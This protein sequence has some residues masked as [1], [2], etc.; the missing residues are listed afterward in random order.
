M[1]TAVG[2][3]N[4]SQPA[5]PR[6]PAAM[7]LTSSTDSPLYGASV[8]LTPTFPAGEQA[9]IGTGGQDSSD[10]AAAAQSG[11]AAASPA[12]TA[13]V[14]YNSG[15]GFQ[16][17]RGLDVEFNGPLAL[18]QNPATGQVYVADSG[19][20]VLRM[21]Q[22]DGTVIA[23]DAKGSIHQ[24]GA[25]VQGAPSCNGWTFWCIDRGGQS[26]PIDLL[27]QQVRADYIA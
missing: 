17:G 14:T 12:L 9:E 16:D 10:L 1:L 3:F 20:N 15:Q 27:R 5:A 24:V 13:P 2:C 22:T 26:V 6:T 18:C 25:F 8:L 19:S 11:V 7:A 23:K 21:L 4:E